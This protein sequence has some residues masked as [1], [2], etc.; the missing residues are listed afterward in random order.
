MYDLIIKNGTVLDPVTGTSTTKNIYINNGKIIETPANE[1]DT[2][3]IKT[4]N[5]SGCYVMPGLID[6]HIHVFEGG[7]QFGGRADLCCPP[8]GVTTVIDAGSAGVYTFE[9]FYKTIILNSTTSIKAAISPSASGVLGPPHEENL[10]PF[11]GSPE[12]M[13]PLFEKYKDVLVGIKQRVHEGVTEII[14]LKSLEQSAKTAE[15]LRKMGYQCNLMV[16]FGNLSEG[17]SV[18]NILDFL[19]EGDVFTHI[20]RPAN[21][22][23]IFGEDGRVLDCIK[24]AKKRG[25][26]FE[27]GCARSHFSCDSVKKGFKDSFLPYIISTDMVRDTNYWSPSGWLA[28]KMS[29]YLNAGMSLRDVVKAVTYNPAKVYGLLDNAGCLDIGMP[30]DVAILKVVD[31]NYLIE[32]MFGG[33]M[34]CNKLIVPMATIKNGNVVFQQIFLG[35][36]GGLSNNN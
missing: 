19:V 18:N 6:A 32:D 31:R 34:E 14:G 25:V 28:L 5:A 2:C 29:I 9:L 8:S 13:F 27:S 24:K 33:S 22:T 1:S 21:G 12:I 4:I 23:T 36:Q 15:K 3:A 16:H 20:Y 10:D 30:A 7:N 35:I 17:V 11:Y 26:I